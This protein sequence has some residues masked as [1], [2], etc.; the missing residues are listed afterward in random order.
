MHDIKY[1][2]DNK[3]DFEKLMKIR[4]LE[5]NVNEIVVM[6]DSYLDSLKK[7]QNY[8]EQK[9]TLSKKFQQLIMLIKMKLKRYLPK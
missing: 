1:I 9:N 6:H 5:I 4:N 2:K 3:K 7:M 8:Q